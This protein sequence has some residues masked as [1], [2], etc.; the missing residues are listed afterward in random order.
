MENQIKVFRVQGDQD[1]ERAFSLRRKVFVDEQ[2]VP[3]ELEL[4]EL[5]SDSQTVHVIAVTNHGQA[6]GVA[7]FRPYAGNSAKV[8]RVAVVQDMRG[9]GVGALLMNFIEQEAAKVGFRELRLNAQTHARGFYERLQ[10]NVHG[11]EFDEAGI[12]HVHMR[13]LI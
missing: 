12:P 7:R 6:I 3:V 2:H 9:S 13:K 8:E 4:D 5:D 11:D 10:Y 1:L